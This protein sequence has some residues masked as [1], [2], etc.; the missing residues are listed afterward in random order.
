MHSPDDKVSLS[1]RI[2]ALS[3]QVTDVYKRQ[4]FINKELA[5]NPL[6]QRIADLDILQLEIGRAHV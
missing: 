1:K 4:E 5:G 3:G 6:R 2:P